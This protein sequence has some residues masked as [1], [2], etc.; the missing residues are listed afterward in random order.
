MV[1]GCASQPPTHTV[2]QLLADCKAQLGKTV[3]VAGYLGTCGGYDCR[4][5]PN[6]AA[7]AAPMAKPDRSLPIGSGSWFD[8]TAPFYEHSYV[9]VTARVEDICQP[10]GFDRV[11]GLAPTDIRRWTVPEGAPS[12][13]H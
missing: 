11:S 12:V 10:F 4:M 2:D 5:A 3:R 7:W 1:G 13:T 9:V 8:L 6:R